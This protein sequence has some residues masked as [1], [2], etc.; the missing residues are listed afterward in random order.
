MAKMH[1]DQAHRSFNK[2]F[3]CPFLKLFT[4][5]VSDE[6]VMPRGGCRG[7]RW[8]GRRGSLARVPSHLPL[9]MPAKEREKCQSKT[10]L[11][12]Q[13]RTWVYEKFKNRRFRFGLRKCGSV[14]ENPRNVSY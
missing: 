2:G 12:N 4:S 10:E 9:T 3:H 14:L 7:R 13:T 6:L 8:L 11:K 5:S 1:A